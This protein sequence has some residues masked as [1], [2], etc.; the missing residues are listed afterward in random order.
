MTS[1]NPNL[2]ITSQTKCTPG[3]MA[4]HL[5]LAAALLL[6]PLPGAA[7]FSLPRAGAPLAVCNRGGAPAFQLAASSNTDADDANP[8]GSSDL[9]SLLPTPKKRT[10]RLDKFGRRIHDL[11]D[12]GTAKFAKE[13]SGASGA[14]GYSGSGGEGGS[15]LG[16]EEAA[17]GMSR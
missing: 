3:T 9:K 17:E 4:K 10:L 14:V 1:H 6:A 12:D 16:S 11:T 5:L 15:S 2:T 13:P 7:P 8:S